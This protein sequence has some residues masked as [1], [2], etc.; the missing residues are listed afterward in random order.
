MRTS[1]VA[2]SLF[3][4]LSLATPLSAQRVSADVAIRSGPVAS[5]VTVGDG[6]STYRRPVVYRRAPARIIVVERVYLRHQ[7]AWRHWQRHGYRPLVVYYRDGRYYDRY[8]RGVPMREVV[9]YERGGRYYHVCDER[10]WRD[11]YQG[12]SR[13]DDHDRDWDD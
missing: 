4:A 5:R 11:H 7:K 6:Y 1:I 9:I 3:V 12:P 10:D 2:G 13:Y 8:V